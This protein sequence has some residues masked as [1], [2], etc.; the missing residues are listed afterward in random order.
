MISGQIYFG[1]V[2]LC[3]TKPAQ[4]EIG[5]VCEVFVNVQRVQQ[6]DTLQ[7]LADLSG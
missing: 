6:I 7:Y 3:S 2:M 5:D 4:D 1:G